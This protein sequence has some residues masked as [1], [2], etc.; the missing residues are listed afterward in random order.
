MRCVHDL[1]A[2]TNMVRGGFQ[3]VAIIWA[4]VAAATVGSIK[5]TDAVGLMCWKMCGV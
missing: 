3:F 4:T 1:V 2:R 5:R